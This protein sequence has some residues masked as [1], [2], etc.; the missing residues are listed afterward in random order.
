MNEMNS[1]SEFHL[2]APGMI[3]AD[4]L[5]HKIRVASHHQAL[6]CIVQLAMF[7]RH[8]FDITVLAET[9]C[10]QYTKRGTCLTAGHGRVESAA[11]CS[12][13]QHHCTPQSEIWHFFNGFTCWSVR[14]QPVSSGSK[15]AGRHA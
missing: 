13:G 8:P 1:M 11:Q 10:M 12:Q 15:P 2:K 5:V 14:F 9:A 4:S 7:G 6:S 3:L